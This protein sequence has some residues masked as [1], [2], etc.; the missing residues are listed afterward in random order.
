[1]TVQTPEP[2]DDE[3]AREAL[4]QAEEIITSE[5]EQINVEAIFQ[6]AIRVG[7]MLNK[8]REL[9]IEG[10]FTEEWV[11]GTSMTLFHKFF[12]PW[13]PPYGEEHDHDDD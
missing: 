9:M 5:A 6:L 12:T 3:A 2:P 8:W 4:R 1:M 7:V 11:E 10:K 13:Y